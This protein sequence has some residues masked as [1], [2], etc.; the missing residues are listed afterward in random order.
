MQ[1]LKKS[2]RANKSVLWFD[3]A[4]AQRPLLLI[5]F[6]G[7]L[8]LNINLLFRSFVL[9]RNNEY[10]LYEK[11]SEL[12]V[13]KAAWENTLKNEDYLQ[14]RNMLTYFTAVLVPTMVM[15]GCW[16]SVSTINIIVKIEALVS[17]VYLGFMGVII[18]TITGVI[19]NIIDNKM[20]SFCLINTVYDYQKF[21]HELVMLSC[22]DKELFMMKAK[23]QLSLSYSEV[24]ELSREF[25]KYSEL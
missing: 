4:Y 18:F 6:F 15:I 21:V 7:Q 10:V 12:P 19:V 25:E 23:K 11:F 13:V 3:L 14:K 20:N 17:L 2:V 9:R 24:L 22:R 5:E 8:W 1:I 16:F